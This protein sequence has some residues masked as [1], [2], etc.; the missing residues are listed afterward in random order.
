[1]MQLNS[2]TRPQGKR[3]VFPL[4]ALALSVLGPWTGPARAGGNGGNSGGTNGN[5]DA[6]SP[7]E[8]TSLPVVGV[9]PTGLTFVGE[10]GEIRALV[11]SIEGRGRIFVER[12]GGGEI[13]ATLQG[14]YE[15][16][17]DR[18]RLARTNVRIQF[19]PG[20]RFA[21]G[22]AH[23]VLWGGSESFLPAQ[24]IALPLSRLAGAPAVQG[25]G[26]S[27]SV[28]GPRFDRYRSIALFDRQHVTLVQIDRG[29]L[30]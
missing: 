3:V 23:L 21:T 24:T 11:L 9:E 12:L 1:M 25:P 7:G 17:L 18:A 13:A 8:V 19:E 15:V 27:L 2:S 10:L 26:L 22:R 4:L 5:V 30:R 28:I 29:S 16:T 14:D 6:S 20:D